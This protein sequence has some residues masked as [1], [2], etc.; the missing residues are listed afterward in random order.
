MPAHATLI[1]FDELIQA[2]CTQESC[3]PTPVDNQYAAL[4]VVFI[5][6]AVYQEAMA[7]QIVSPPNA[8]SDWYGP[9]MQI[10]FTGTLPTTVSMY[11]SAVL[12]DSIY[13]TAY[14]LSGQI[15]SATTDGWRGTEET[16]TPYRDQQLITFSGI[17]AISQITLD[18]LFSRRG[19][20]VI[21]NLEFS[22]SVPL[23]PALGLFASGLGFLFWRSRS[24]R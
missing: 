12:Q 5:N 2:P 1:N 11:V 19:T 17:G 13:L 22:A 7:P 18:S 9:G 24:S 21:D 23:P 14:G 6:A 16:S 15:G 8:I 10:H 20:L 4:G 3:D